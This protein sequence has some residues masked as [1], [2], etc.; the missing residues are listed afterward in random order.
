ML[1][2]TEAEMPFQ[3]YSGT[4]E[5]ISLTYFVGYAA[6][7]TTKKWQ[8]DRCYSELLKPPKA[9]GDRNDTYIESREYETKTNYKVTLL[10]K[11]SEKFREIVTAKAKLHRV[12]SIDNSNAIVEKKAKLVAHVAKKQY[13]EVKRKSNP[14]VDYKQPRKLRNLM[15]G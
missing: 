3:A 7:V 10:K 9:F 15:H 2:S 4:Y 11:P 13:R 12:C 1:H 14:E 8:C 5:G 6:H